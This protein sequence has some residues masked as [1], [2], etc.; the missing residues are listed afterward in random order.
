M[1]GKAPCW[2]FGGVRGLLNTLL[3]GGVAYWWIRTCFIHGCSAQ[4]TSR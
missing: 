4:M 2:Q 3:C 1:N